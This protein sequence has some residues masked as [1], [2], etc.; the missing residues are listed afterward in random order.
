[1]ADANVDIVIDCADP[2]TLAEF[3]AEA[4]GYDK[5]GPFDNYYVLAARNRE[6]SPVILQ[7]VPEPKSGK[8]RIHFD[9]RVP[10]IEPEAK[11]LEALGARRI[12]I[13]QGDD[14]GWIAMADPEGN[15]FC[16]CPG[17]PLPP[18]SPTE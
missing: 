4:L 6:H 1:M 15:E 9:L 10:D 3:W 18:T 17:V 16:V 2:E 13:G 14:P 11:R 7:R 8:A 12:D 5:V